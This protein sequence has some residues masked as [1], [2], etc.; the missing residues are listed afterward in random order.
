MKIAVMCL[1]AFVGA[2]G[3]SVANGKITQGKLKVDCFGVK[4]TDT[5]T[6][7]S[8][9]KCGSMI[10]QVSN[11]YK[12]NSRGKL[13]ISGKGHLYKSPLK[14]SRRAYRKAV[15]S[16]KG[17]YKS[18]LYMIP[19]R[20]TGNHAGSKVAHLKGALYSTAMHE[21][22]HLLGLGH[23]GSY[24]K[25]KGKWKLDHYGDGQS[26]MSRFP[27]A[28]LTAPQLFNHK[29]TPKA[30]IATYTPNGPKEFTLKRVSAFSTKGLAVIRVPSQYFH[31]QI[32]SER[33][34]GQRDAFISFPLKCKNGC[35]VIH[36]SKGGSSQ[37]VKMFGNEYYDER[38]TSL[39]IK[40]LGYENGLIRISVG[41]KMDV[42]SEAAGL[43]K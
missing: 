24:K 33:I 28:Y 6:F 7:V 5:K 40:K 39:H 13:I 31:G 36:L 10:R 2:L 12:R 35:V 4:Y 16:I 42:E 27:S 23:A 41:F 32:D 11:F 14:G 38:F 15:A 18:D 25:V 17:K 29:W 20:F 22:G 21:V 1:A 37:R 8:A 34:A 9:S 43:N 19:G 26:V 3:F 30:E